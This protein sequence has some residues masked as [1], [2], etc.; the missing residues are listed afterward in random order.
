MRTFKIALGWLLAGFLLIQLIRIDVPEPPR[1]APGDEIQAPA[2]I[3]PLLK[4]ACYDCHSNETKWPWYAEISPI[5]LEV[6]AHVKNGRSW[7]NFSIWNRYDEKKQ[8]KLYKGIVKSIDWKMPPADY[9][10]IHDEARL[11]PEERR[12]IKEWAQSRVTE[13]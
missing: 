7:L 3:K 13:E 9:M 2:A 8:Q 6:K 4:K 10:W 12:Q 5:S 11:T 1:A